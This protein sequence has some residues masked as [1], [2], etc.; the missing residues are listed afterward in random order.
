[1]TSVETVSDWAAFLDLE[2]DW[3]DAVDRAGI[4][5][6]FLRHEWMRTWWECFGTGRHLFIVVVRAGHSVEAIAPFMRQTTSMYGVPAR[7]LALWHNDHTPRAD[8]VVAGRPDESYR[9]I[10]RAVAGER[11][12]WDVLQLA[13]LP[14]ESTTRGAL[15]ELARADG[16]TTG[17]WPSGSSPYLTLTGTWDEY[18]RGLS[19]K[20]RQNLRNRLTRLRKIGEPA[21]EVVSGGE[22]VPAACE[23]AIR[24][25]GAAWKRTAGTA[26]ASDAAVGGLYRAFAAQAS[27][28]GWLRLM[29]LTVDGRRIATAYSLLYRRRL[30][31]FKTGYDPLY[32]TCSPFKV[33]TYFALRDAFARGIA[34][35]DFLGDPEPWKLE[36][37]RTTRAHDW[38]FTFSGSLRA[39]ALAAMKLRIVPALK[40]RRAA[41]SLLG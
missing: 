12:R 9:A 20:F 10:W 29:F 2:A 6:P 3:N 22:A 7:C 23:D 40:R 30:F 26:I 38:L 18:A 27:R 32:A 17:V 13:Q 5:H 8:V 15:A 11:A 25:E 36:W 19:A 41:A 24:L 16:C 37:T 14:A 33:L 39:R 28:R 34:E 31:L 1:M 4:D 21:L 35:V